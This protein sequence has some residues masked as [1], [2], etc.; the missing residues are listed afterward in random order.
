[1]AVILVE[2]ATQLVSG[3]DAAIAAELA[4]VLRG[5]NIDIRLG[6]EVK[7][8]EATAGG[9]ARALLDGGSMIEAER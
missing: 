8:M 9:Q 1:V 3:E 7:A 2:A 5:R 6:T 4:T